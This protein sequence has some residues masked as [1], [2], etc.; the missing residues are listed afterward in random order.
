MQGSEKVGYL[1]DGVG[2]GSV[3]VGAGGREGFNKNQISLDF[4]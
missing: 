1:Q 4:L 2:W 3:C